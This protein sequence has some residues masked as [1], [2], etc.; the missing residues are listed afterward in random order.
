MVSIKNIHYSYIS[1]LT[2]LNPKDS[3]DII[4]KTDQS[5]LF[6]GGDKFKCLKLTKKQ[7]K[8]ENP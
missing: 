8:K 4:I 3:N 5:F 6:I 7:N 1:C 2:L